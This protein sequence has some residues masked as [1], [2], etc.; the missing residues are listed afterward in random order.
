MAAGRFV[1]YYRASTAQ[2]GR[3]GLGLDAQRKAVADFL[4]GGAWA[5]VGEFTGAIGRSWRRRCRP[6]GCTGGKGRRDVPSELVD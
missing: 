4:N 6:A 5:L 3:S 2:Q 1:A